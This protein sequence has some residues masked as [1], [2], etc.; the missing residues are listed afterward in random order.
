MCYTAHFYL[1]FLLRMFLAHVY[2]TFLLGISVAHVYCTCSLHMFIIP[3]VF[4]PRGKFPVEGSESPVENS[5]SKLPPC[6][7]HMFIAHFYCTRL[8]HISIAH[9]SFESF[10]YPPVPVTNAVASN[11]LGSDAPIPP[12]PNY[13]IPAAVYHWKPTAIGDMRTYERICSN[14]DLHD[15]L[16]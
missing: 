9:V 15:K 16:I 6:S 8:F 3:E 12:H 14:Y 5:E 10:C 4:Y 2:C 13:F 1:T 7:L 11:L